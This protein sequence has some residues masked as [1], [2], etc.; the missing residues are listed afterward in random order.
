MVVD[1]DQRIDIVVITWNSL[2]YLKCCLNSIRKHTKDVPYRLIVVD[3]GSKDGTGKFLAKH[4]LKNT[5]I[6]KNKK[7]LG[8]PKALSQ[9]YNL[10]RSEY[11]CLMN[12]DVIVSPK[13]LSKLLKVMKR[14]PDIGILGPVRPGA[15]FV[16]P[17]TKDLSKIVLEKS[18]IKRRS[19]VDQLKYFTCGREYTSFVRDYK[20]VNKPSIVRYNSLPHIISTC[21]AV[22]RRKAVEKAGGIVDT[23]FVKYG[24]DDV[25][26]SWRLIKSGFTLA[27]T[28]ESYVHHF[29]HVSMVMN[30]VDRQKYLKINAKRL[31]C[32]W[33][34]DIKR[35]LTLQIK[36][37]LAREQI[38]QG[39]WLLQRLVDAVGKEFWE[40]V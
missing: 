17:Y 39:N 1:M 19:P 24:G 15:Y 14:N 38:L 33:K 10:T 25:D 35:Y 26:L 3:N 13:W 21:C 27:V 2:E 30:K 7:N 9:G 40:G 20:N 18:K 8:Y 28:S 5:L 4:P 29:E 32:K 16:H 37:G 34:K 31:Y 22:I 36:Q 23:R 6:K 12:D 11:V